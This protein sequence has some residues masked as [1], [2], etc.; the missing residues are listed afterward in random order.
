[1]YSEANEQRVEHIPGQLALDIEF[2]GQKPER[3]RIRDF[4]RSKACRYLGGLALVAGS[5]YVAGA[6]EAAFVSPTETTVA[7]NNADGLL[8]P[9]DQLVLDLGPA[10]T[11]TCPTPLTKG[12]LSVGG[13]LRLKG[14]D[15]AFLEPGQSIPTTNLEVLAGLWSDVESIQSTVQS[16][17]LKHM[18]DNGTKA[19]V[20]GGF[21][22]SA[23]YWW[24]G[25][26]LRR[27]I[28][29]HNKER[30]R[31]PTTKIAIAGL[32]I[33]AVCAPP[34]AMIVDDS[35]YALQ[36]DAQLDRTMLEGCH[37][38]NAELRDVVISLINYV[39]YN[40]SYSAEVVR[41]F[42]AANRNMSVLQADKN[43]FTSTLVGP[44]HSN[45]ITPNLLETI[46][47]SARSSYTMIPGDIT[48]SGSK[49]ENAY[50]SMLAYRTKDTKRIATQGNH[51]SSDTV[52]ALRDA[53]FEVQNG[54]IQEVAGRTILGDR[55]PRRSE[56]GRQVYQELDETETQLGER[57]QQA[58]CE[59]KQE[60]NEQLFAVIV[61]EPHAA[62][63][64][65]VSGCAKLV[66]TA[67]EE[68]KFVQITGTNGQKTMYA[69]LGSAAGSKDGE[70]S[71]SDFKDVAEI[72]VTKHDKTTGAVIATQT[73]RIYPNK[74]VAITQPQLFYEEVPSFAGV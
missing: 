8:T 13:T 50:I 58:A 28:H 3:H 67:G 52:R 2:S 41:N 66:V 63:A 19:A 61:N 6:A 40:R 43:S 68:T 38:S 54:Q 36:G 15:P 34:I 30:L 72:S 1:M 33:L 65:A 4:V 56:F 21:L 17:F 29:E 42:D 37:V 27:N 11:I 12:P 24:A 7:T 5:F 26:K 46:S 31:Q 47:K 45:M 20:I 71:I 74:Q 39:Q 59:Y 57:L 25:D 32:G 51:D 70:I 23:Y 18:H 53:G 14:F 55:S 64:S 44:L 35:A 49:I 69:I 48:F 60:H 62:E 16:D 22:Y 9:G 10:D 73:I